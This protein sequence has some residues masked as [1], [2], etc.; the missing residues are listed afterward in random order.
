MDEFR[1]LTSIDPTSTIGTVHLAAIA[2][3]TSF[4]DLKA[5]YCS[6]G[7]TKS[8]LRLLLMD[9]RTGIEPVFGF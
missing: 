3:F 8:Q 7:M 2:R 6:G 4:G 9:S 1:S 5:P